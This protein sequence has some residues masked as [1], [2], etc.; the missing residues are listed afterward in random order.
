MGQPAIDEPILEVS[1]HAVERGYQR[2]W[3]QYCARSTP[4]E[5]MAEWLT[6]FSKEAYKYSKPKKLIHP[7][8]GAH[9][10]F[11]YQGITLVVVN[12][13]PTRATVV[14]VFYGRSKGQLPEVISG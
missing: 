12:H 5:S 2:L 3:P 1:R 6:R 10:E 8:K 9:L 14:T 4:N 7:E 13:G 11:Y